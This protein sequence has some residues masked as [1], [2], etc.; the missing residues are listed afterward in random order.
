MN[1]HAEYCITIR[2]TAHYFRHV[3]ES[4]QP[5]RPGTSWCLLC[6]HGLELHH[7]F[8]WHLPAVRHR[9]MQASRETRSVRV[10]YLQGSDRQVI[11]R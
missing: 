7:Q 8:G 9:I 4:S 10:R 6:S 2:Y 3:R 1:D 5:R 11:P